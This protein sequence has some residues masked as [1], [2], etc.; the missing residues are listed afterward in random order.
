M[1]FKELRQRLDE[2]TVKLGDPIGGYNPP[3][4][5]ERAMMVG[6]EDR[7]MDI[8]RQD[9]AA[10]EKRQDI[11]RRYGSGG[12]DVSRKLLRTSAETTKMRLPDFGTDEATELAKEMTPGQNNALG[13]YWTMRDDM[14][15]Q[16]SESK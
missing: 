13:N 5:A 10:K 11:Q 12:R 16:R 3:K 8:M 6:D 9:I 1:K 14:S 4:E 2:L 7:A 15:N